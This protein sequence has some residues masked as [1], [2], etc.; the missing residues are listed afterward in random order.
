MIATLDDF[1]VR[2]LLGGV[3]VAIVAGPLGCFVVW[4]RMAYFGDTMAHS[5]LL[6]VALSLITG[7]EPTLG[8]LGV[9][10]ACALLL[11]TLQTRLPLASDTLL[12]ILSHG[13]LAVGLVVVGT[14]PAIRIDLF[15]LLFGDILAIGRGDLAVIYGG[16]VVALSVLAVLWRALLAETVQPEVAAAEG[17]RPTRARFGYTVL[18]AGIIAIAMKVVGILLITALLVIPAATARRLS[19]TPEAMAVAASALGAVAVA[20]GLFASLEA[21][22]P[23]G[24]TIVVVALLLFVVVSLAAAIRRR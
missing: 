8:V 20:G 11:L 1:F 22:S 23:S 12:G 17:M 6:G 7:T 19:R 14:M 24:P 16:A 13:A 18:L 3:G 10:V 4:R 5:A 15:S 21:D 9:S 2:A